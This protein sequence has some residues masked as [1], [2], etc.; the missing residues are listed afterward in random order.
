VKKFL[1]FAH[2]SLLIVAIILGLLLGKHPFLQGVRDDKFAL[3]QI[4]L[5]IYFVLVFLLELRRLRYLTLR[6]EL[7][8]KN[9][10]HLKLFF[11][12]MALLC[13][14]I[15]FLYIDHKLKDLTSYVVFS[16]VC[17]LSVVCFFE[18]CRYLRRPK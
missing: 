11:V 5:P 10:P 6:T 15:W 16:I 13:S 7:R 12:Q 14:G 17:Y 2:G 1:N 9:N 3:V 18:T 8:V 4:L